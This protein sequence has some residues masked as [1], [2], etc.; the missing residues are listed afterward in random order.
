MS[1]P[2]APP[3]PPPLDSPCNSRRLGGAAGV[4]GAL[5][6]GG[7]DFHRE[8]PMAS[9]IRFVAGLALSLAFLAAPPAPGQARTTD[10]GARLL[11]FPFDG[12]DLPEATRLGAAQAFSMYLSE[13]GYHVFPVPEDVRPG[14]DLNVAREAASRSGADAFVLGYVTRLGETSIVQIRAYPIAGEAPLFADHLTVSRA[15]DMEPALVRLAEA[16]ATGG[17]AA[18]VRDI[19]T[20]TEREE[21]E[22][23]R[24]KAAGYFGVRLGGASFVAGGPDEFLTGFGIYG[25]YDARFALFDISASGFGGGGS[26]YFALDLGGYYPLTQTAISPYL[27][28]GLSLSSLSPDR[29]NPDGGL[30]VFAGAG[31]L[32]ARTSSVNLRADVRYLVNTYQTGGETGDPGDDELGHG[33]QFSAGLNF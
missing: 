32:I 5:Q 17:K 1:D 20:V 11:V 10:P 18:S 4:A 24:E 30:G 22:L 15:E 29:G 16:M 9:G 3:A 28:G 13:R 31:L 25:L 33:V 23:R 6:W 26:S 7:P 8:D 14:S 21:R 19:Y 27:G 12:I 2:R